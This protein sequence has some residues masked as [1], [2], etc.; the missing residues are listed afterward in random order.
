VLGEEKKERER[1]DEMS[2]SG[3]KGQDQGY[4][5]SPWRAKA[6]DVVVVCLDSQ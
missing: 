6:R 2:P 3:E 1:Q 5:E 4:G